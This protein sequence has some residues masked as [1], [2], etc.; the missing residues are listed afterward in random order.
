MG[1]PVLQHGDPWEGEGTGG[2]RTADQGGAQALGLGGWGDKVTK[3]D[4]SV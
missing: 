3:G 1:G 4:S 2:Q